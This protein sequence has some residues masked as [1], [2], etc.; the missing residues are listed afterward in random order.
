MTEITSLEGP[1]DL[2]DDQLVL[3]IPLEYGGDKLAPFAKGIG[4]VEGDS[5]TI[6]IQ[7]WLAEKLQISAGS[8]VVVDNRNDKLNITRSPTNGPPSSEGAV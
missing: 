5:L 8:L 3:S 4:V 6:V 2:V 1:V 7:P